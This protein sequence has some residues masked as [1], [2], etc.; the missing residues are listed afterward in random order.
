MT[1]APDIPSFPIRQGISCFFIPDVQPPAGF[2]IRLRHPALPTGVKAGKS[3]QKKWTG[4]DQHPAILMKVNAL[5][6]I[7]HLSSIF[8][9]VGGLGIR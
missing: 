5:H 9:I 6:Q 7:T 8:L 3:W 2:L 4:K 1:V